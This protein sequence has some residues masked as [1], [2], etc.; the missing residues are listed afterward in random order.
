MGKMPMP[1]MGPMKI[2]GEPVATNSL[3]PFPSF[4]RMPSFCRKPSMFF[5]P[6]RSIRTT[7]SPARPLGA[8]AAAV[9]FLIAIFCTPFFGPASAAETGAA[10]PLPG[11]PAKPLAAP[12]AKS[13]PSPT[14]NLDATEWVVFVADVANPMLNARSL[15]HDSLPPQAEDLR[16][17]ATADDA[18]PSQSG[19]AADPGLDVALS[20]GHAPSVPASSASAS[21][22]LPGPIGLIRFSADG[23]VDKETAVDVQIGFK[24]GRV[25]GHWPRAK[26]RSAGLLWQDLNLASDTGELHKLP[27]GSWLA[28]LRGSGLSLRAGTT[29]EPFLLYDVE[30][31]YPLAIQVKVGE[32]GKYSVAHG[33]DAALRDLTFY[34]RDAD[35]WRTASVASLAK[36]AGFPKPVAP[37]AAAPQPK[38]A[39][40]QIAVQTVVNG[41]V[42]TEMRNMRS[43][44]KADSTPPAAVP[45]A[46]VKGTEIALGPATETSDTVLAPWRGKLAKAGV[47]AADQDVIL[48]ILARHA[49][50]PKR[51]TA[52]Y[53]LDPAELDRILPLEIVP[54]PKKVSRIALVIV[55]GIDP[56][57]GD[58]LDQLIKKLG[59][60]SWKIRE[61][62]T[63]G[64]K[65]MGIRAKSRLQKV[66]NDKDVEVA[67]RAEE[68]LAGIASETGEAP[69]DGGANSAPAAGGF[70]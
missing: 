12:T 27:E 31:P 57:I 64:I 5:L 65:K 59:D 63:A 25:L 3:F 67:Y 68:L 48:K 44:T 32:K 47:S 60:P 18:K 36:A 7:T 24:G 56:A 15:F 29:R 61:A 16:S 6:E 30:F 69:G 33:M 37:A 54:Q 20:E 35:H 50:D 40:G 34:N 52:I 23:K 62:A 11:Q 46:A 4:S 70:F 9:T 45:S 19:T 13:L 26:V 42:V 51:L 49:L 14:I 21:P 66:V 58:E 10:K 2:S 55:R 53:R 8:N 39:R 22:S 28:Q 41:T 38:G 17:A 43:A 1:R